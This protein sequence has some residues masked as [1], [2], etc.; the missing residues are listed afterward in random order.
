MRYAIIA[1]GEGSRLRQ[2]GIAVPKPLI[3]VNG[4][5]LIDRLIRI[6]TENG[7]TEIVV[8]CNGI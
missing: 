6:F 5:R 3:M 1:A 4:E 7:A 8:I 2:E